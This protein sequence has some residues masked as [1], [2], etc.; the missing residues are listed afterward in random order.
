MDLNVLLTSDQFRIHALRAGAR[1]MNLTNVIALLLLA[2]TNSGVFAAEPSERTLSDATPDISTNH[3]PINADVAKQNATVTSPLSEKVRPKSDLPQR[4]I[5]IRVAGAQIPV[6]ADISANVATIGRAI[7]FAQREKADVLVTPEGSLSGYRASFDADETA[8]ANREIVAKAAAANIA[9]VLGTCFADETGQRYDG[10]RFY[11]KNGDFLGFHS[12]ILLCR[13]M[14]DPTA[15]GEVDSF[16]S[17]P[18][19]VFELQ[20]LTVGGLVCNDLWANPE[21]TPMPDP[22]LARQLAKLGAR[23]IF[24]SVNAGQDDG[25]NWALNHAF[26]EANLRM[27][28]RSAGV[29]IVVAEAADPAGRKR[30]NS[31]SGVVDPDG[32]WAVQ[33]DSKGEQF[34]AHTIELVKQQ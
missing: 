24:H 26:H 30:S 5:R 28:A 20:G 17:T 21:W 27:R 23:I 19:R 10:Q 15:K 18:L 12:K 31:P 11:D 29:W 13:K 7:A 32:H 22:Y 33:A 25:E 3:E 6:S 2:L 4:C 1:S 9:L 16:K 34:F 14:A 8:R